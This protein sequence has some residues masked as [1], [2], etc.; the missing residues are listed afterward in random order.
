M[1]VR[2][3]ERLGIGATMLAEPCNLPLIACVTSRSYSPSGSF[4]P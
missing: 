2:G 4:L 1:R 3:F